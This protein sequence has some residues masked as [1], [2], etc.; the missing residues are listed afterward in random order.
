MPASEPFLILVAAFFAAAG[1]VAG[2]FLLLRKPARARAAGFRDGDAGLGWRP[3][4]AG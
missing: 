4:V 1:L 2:V 3:G